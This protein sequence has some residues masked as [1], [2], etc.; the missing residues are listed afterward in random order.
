MQ[1]K[2]RGIVLHYLKYGESSMIVTLYTEKFGRMAFLMQGT[3]SKKT[4][5]KANL[6]Q[7]LFLLEMEVAHKPGRDLQRV[8]ELRTA[9]PFTSIPYD[10]IKSTQVMFLSE[11]LNKVLREEESNPQ[12]FDFLYHAILFLDLNEEG[13]ANFHLV[14]LLQLARYLGFGLSPTT[15]EH[16]SYFDLESGTFSPN[17]PEHP[18][19]LNQTESGAFNQLINTGFNRLNTLHLNRLLRDK[20]LDALIAYYG[21]HLGGSLN[22]KSLAILQELFR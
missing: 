18:H 6:F 10:V 16:A 12:L 19:F 4:K 1:N 11:V 3:R 17:Q 22:I 15:S 21:L 2:T 8:R 20:L 13:T 14:F 5:A 9:A 7:P